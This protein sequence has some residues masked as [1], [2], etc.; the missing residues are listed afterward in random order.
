MNQG[1]RIKSVRTALGLTLEKFGNRLGVGK[2]AISKIE[3]G[4]NRLSD[5]M[6]RSISREFN[7]SYEWLTTGTGEMFL[8]ETDDYSEIINRVMMSEN[9]FYKDIFRTFSKLSDDELS[10]LEKILDKFIEVR[11]ESSKSGLESI[12]PIL[13]A[14]HE[15]TDIDVSEEMRIHDDSIMEDDSEWE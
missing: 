8:E 1:A 13:A 15:R 4:E 3:R 7:V 5:Q 14:A 11:N 10:T 2:T 6:A 12:A 9:K